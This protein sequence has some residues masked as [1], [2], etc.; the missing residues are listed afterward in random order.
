MAKKVWIKMVG[1]PNGDPPRPWQVGPPFLP[2]GI[3]VSDTPIEVLEET[4][5]ILMDPDNADM[6]RERQ[7]EVVDPPKRRTYGAA[8]AAKPSTTGN[9]DT[10]PPA[11]GTPAA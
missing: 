5:L 2:E 8:A 10:R 9:A 7:F 11:T 1:G 3:E 6:C 4:A